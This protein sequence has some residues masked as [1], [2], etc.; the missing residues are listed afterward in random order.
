M[1]SMVEESDGGDQRAVADDD[2]RTVIDRQ[3]VSDLLVRYVHA[4][5]NR[6]WAVVEQCFTADAV[7]IHPGGRVEG[8]AAIVSRAQAALEPL[9][10][11]QHLL[12]SVSVTVDGDAAQATSYFHAQHIRVG[13]P[14]GG[15]Y[16][17]AG[18]YRDRLCRTAA[19]W[20]IF[21]RAQEYSWRSGNPDVIVRGQSPE[22][23]S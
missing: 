22:Q 18:T 19:G 20:A 6:D 9:D 12:G 23:Q 17:I 10:G 14:G 13:A 3:A 8:A 15:L 7:F 16:V 4:L 2:V 1:S 11:S 5:D 21:E